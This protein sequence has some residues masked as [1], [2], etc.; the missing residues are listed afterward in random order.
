MDFAIV[1]S[2]LLIG[3]GFAVHGYVGSGPLSF[4]GGLIVAV[5]A[6]GPVTLAVGRGRSLG[7]LRKAA[8]STCVFVV[9][10]LA[11]EC[12]WRGVEAVRPEP[13]AK[14]FLSY[15]AARANPE[16]FRRWWNEIH[17]R[18][19][20]ISHQ[21]MQPD[22]RKLVPHVPIPAVSPRQPLARINQL[23]FRGPEIEREKGDRYRIVALGESTTWGLTILPD[24]RTWP[25]VLEARI[26]AEFDCAVPVEVV[27]AGVPGWSLVHQVAR[28]PHDI[29][30]LRPDLILSY[31]GY[32][33]FDFF[34]KALPAVL[35]D[36][37]P[38]LP[39]RPSRILG[40]MEREVR[41]S[42][43]RRR[44][45][46]AQRLHASEISNDT[47][48]R[49]RANRHAGHYERLVESVRSGGAQVVLAT[50][51]MAVNAESPE[52]AIR[53]YEA[54][55]P[56]VRARIVAN[57][58]HTEVVLD[59]GRRLGV[60]TLDTSPGLDGAYRD[61]YVDIAHFNQLGRER[62]AAH[63][64]AGLR[65]ILATHPRSRCRPRAG[66]LDE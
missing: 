11:A 17:I 16:G 4:F 24:D 23:G 57:R 55:V 47:R 6:L 66:S 63:M 52:Q 15:E 36:E 56:D 29:L 3:V 58:I 60:R 61:A 5:V 48:V 59:V 28:L 35:V 44:Y 62:L 27:N 34:L 65:E 22:P 21:I 1:V 19:F 40:A 49:R 45:R 7:V 25:E 8:L 53:F 14:P 13:Q 39:P 2:L 32:N 33:G 18:F 41:I 9:V 43:F 10:L 38:A 42:W 31:H 26:R 64:L 50:F 20:R 46:Q 54:I 37:P 12:V 30:P 51:N